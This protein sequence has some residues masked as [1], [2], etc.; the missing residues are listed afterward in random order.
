MVK[1]A[2]S[3]LGQFIEAKISQCEGGSEGSMRTLLTI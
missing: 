1:M 2:S 3:R